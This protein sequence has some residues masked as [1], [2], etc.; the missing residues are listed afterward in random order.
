MSVEAGIKFN[1]NN[2]VLDQMINSL[3]ESG[4]QAG[5]SQAQIDKM[6]RSFEDAGKAGK[7][8]TDDV[9]KGLSDIESLAKK[10]GAAFIAVFAVNK[11]KDA[12][13]ALYENAAFLE[14]VDTKAKVVFGNYARYV[15]Q[16]GESMAN[17]VGM[18]EKQFL[19]VSSGVGDLLIPM[20]FARKEAAKLSTELI[21]LSGALSNWTGGTKS[22]IEVSEILTNALLGNNQAL[23]GL[24]IAISE[25]DVQMKLAEKGQK[26]L[27]GAAYEQARAL[28][29]LELIYAKSTD[30]QDAFKKSQDV[31][32][33]AKGQIVGALRDIGDS[34]ASYLTPAFKA[35]TLAARDFTVSLKEILTFDASKEFINNFVDAGMDEFEKADLPGKR[36]I[37]NDLAKAIQ[38]NRKDV[39]AW[40]STYRSAT[41]SIEGFQK[42]VKE[43]GLSAEQAHESLKKINAQSQ[44]WGNVLKAQEKLMENHII[45]WKE[46]NEE[47]QKGET[48]LGLIEEKTIALRAAMEK[49]PKLTNVMDIAKTNIQIKE[50]QEEIKFL[51]EFTGRMKP[52]ELVT[53]KSLME[54]KIGLEGQLKLIKDAYAQAEI[55]QK[56]S[57][58]R[59]ETT[60]E[61]YERRKLEIKLKYLRMERAALREHGKDTVDITKQILDTEIQLF[62]QAERKK[63]EIKREQEEI[64]RRTLEE[65]FHVSSYLA[66]SYMEYE[67]ALSDQRLSALQAGKAHELYLAGDNA[68]AK[69]DIERNYNERIRAERQKSAQM[70]KR[71]AIFNALLYTFQA[72]NRALASAAPPINFIL[73]GMVATAGMFQVKA[74]Q[75]RP[76]P[77]FKDGVYN[78]KGP[79]TETSDSIPANLSKSE[80]VVS[81][82]KSKNFGWLLKPLIEDQAFD[83][84]KL[85]HLVDKNIPVQL[86]G[87][88]FK[89]RSQKGIDY[90]KMSAA[91]VPGIVS[92]IKSQP[93]SD[94]SID[95]RGFNT[96]FRTRASKVQRLN[97]RRRLFG[98]G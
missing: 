27:T 47:Q 18:S 85:R 83:N 8:G 66:N 42:Y 31:M 92:A 61:D 79:G 76:V 46:L 64:R 48:R 59:E 74:I 88:L 3:R 97:N 28:A 10:A 5:L 91:I 40:T 36:K 30:A 55:A 25:N 70:E 65:T 2:K 62:E 12:T 68:K 6:T 39:E 94:I 33:S 58:L 51:Q 16:V 57:Y 60:K 24:G 22:S 63:T 77:G 20:G 23:K 26:N 82:R 37:I 14:K 54:V 9:K 50:L 29:T 17:L 4:K 72:A 41:G 73:A 75:N 34:L 89:S 52:V 45:A 1:I 69:E 19:A 44:Y 78:L 7:K 80:S 98:H 67:L 21:S 15:E 93:V 96:Y 43:T 53:P 49:L 13:A 71:I 11:I 95:N 32:I 56:E 35:V 87:D 81:A 90:N 86:R 38:D 84:E